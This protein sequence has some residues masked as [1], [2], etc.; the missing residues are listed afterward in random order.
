MPQD[1]APLP[2]PADN[3]PARTARRSLLQW[4]DSAAVPA[5]GGADADRVDWLRVLP[6]VLLHL[7][8]IGVPWVG[9]SP[10]AVLVA[11][12]LYVVRMFA[13]DRLLPPLFL[14]SRVPHLASACSSCSH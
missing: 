3:A 13:I 6:F 12:L 11:T 9:V 14:A 7:G 4:F 8:C 1:P 5:A 10:V 2:S